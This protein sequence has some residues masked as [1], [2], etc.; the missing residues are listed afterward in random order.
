M[1]ST[2]WEQGQ[3]GCSLGMGLF[4]MF[5]WRFHSSGVLPVP[6]MPGSLSN[7]KGDFPGSSPLR[8]EFRKVLEGDEGKERLDLPLGVGESSP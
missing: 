5:S 8:N 2:A 6:E 1:L 3:L 4:L 7:I